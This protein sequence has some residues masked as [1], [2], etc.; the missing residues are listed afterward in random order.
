MEH[1][2]KAKAA[3]A[4]RT[5]DRFLIW[6]ANTF[7]GFYAKRRLGLTVSGASCL[8]DS[9]PYLILANH[10]AMLDFLY[11]YIACRPHVPH[12]VV[13]E[14]FYHSP[15]MTRLLNRLGC[16][17]KRQFQA[18]PACIRSIAAA[19]KNGDG[20]LLF[21]EGQIN[22]YGA[23]DGCPPGSGKLIKLFCVPVYLLRIKGSCLTKPKWSTG[24]ARKGKIHVTITPLFTTDMIKAATAAELEQQAEAAV[25][26][27]EYEHQKTVMQRYRGKNLA[28][29]FCRM[30][31][32]CP[33]CGS[34][35]TM[36]AVGDT[37]TC[38][39]CGN[40]GVMDEYGLIRPADSRCVIPESPA[41]WFAFQRAREA[42]LLHE[43]GAHYC[44][45]SKAAFML[46]W[47]RGAKT[48]YA[49]TAAGIARLTPYAIS[50]TGTDDA[51]KPFSRS[52]DVASLS[53]LPFSRKGDVQIPLYGE[54]VA[55]RPVQA[56]E[57]GRWLAAW[58]AI[59]DAEAAGTLPQAL[60]QSA[61][62]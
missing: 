1:A 41:D 20:V 33:R 14:F 40:R 51:G 46:P 59:K 9:G 2:S 10:M 11:A 29:G 53:K 55:I 13:A 22:G 6:L 50:F 58:A 3:N 57:S 37:I 56:D 25:A 23:Y 35:Y 30:A 31:Y 60:P 47:G 54:V 62:S 28:E 44:V 12:A 24:K 21:P 26:F 16:I 8:P 15:F 38:N 4:P 7:G 19:L 32:L 18:D 61:D 45:E 5:P 43:L 52:Y 27:N 49:E 48:G 17:K 34:R 39:A 36:A 42:R